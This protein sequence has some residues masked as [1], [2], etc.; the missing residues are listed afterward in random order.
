MS[1]EDRT[2]DIE[3]VRDMK[4]AAILSLYRFE[5]VAARWVK[6]T[7]RVVFSHIVPRHR[8]AEFNEI[9]ALCNENHNIRMVL[10]LD[11]LLEVAESDD[12]AGAFAELPTLGGYERAFQGVR[13]TIDVLKK[14]AEQDG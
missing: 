9:V 12:P 2:I 1:T 8:A 14:E 5:I 6:K 10:S 13:R 7:S 3:M 11:E 4:T